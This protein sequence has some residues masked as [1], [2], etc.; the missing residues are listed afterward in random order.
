MEVKIKKLNSDAVIPKKST[1]GAAAYDVYTPKNYTIL[2]GRRMILPLGFSIEIPY[3]YEA[4]IEP[5]SGF[6]AK[7]FEGRHVEAETGEEFVKRYD[8]D[9]IVG[10]IDSDYR[11]EVGVIV[12]S[13]ETFIV[14]KGTRIA[15]MT[16]YKVED[17]CFNEVENLSETER[18]DGGFGHSGTN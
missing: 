9:V 5:R 18:A 12:K 13:N 1:V 17:A 8:A 2:E 15:Q 4:K 16:I 14:N 6:S 10:K 11:G 7:G 3:G